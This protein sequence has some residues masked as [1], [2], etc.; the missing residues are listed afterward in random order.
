[1]HNGKE[2][3]VAGCS[4]YRMQGGSANMTR[5]LQDIPIYGGR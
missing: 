4:Y 3:T 5:I 1:M 2:A